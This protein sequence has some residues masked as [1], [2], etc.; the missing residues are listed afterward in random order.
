MLYSFMP[1]LPLY[2][3]AGLVGTLAVYAVIVTSKRPLTP[4]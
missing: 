2:V 3:S 1:E 4:S